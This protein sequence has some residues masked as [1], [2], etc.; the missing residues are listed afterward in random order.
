MQY[1]PG[2]AKIDSH[3]KKKKQIP[4]ASK[5]KDQRKKFKPSFDKHRL[6]AFLNFHLVEQVKK[7]QNRDLS[8]KPDDKDGQLHCE[9]NFSGSDTFWL[10]EEQ[11]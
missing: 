4:K 5:N 8:S 11:E 3:N 10:Q 7:K 9:G 1:L 6:F 2:H